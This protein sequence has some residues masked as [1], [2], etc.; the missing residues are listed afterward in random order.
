MPRVHKQKR[1]GTRLVIYLALHTVAC[2]R[3]GYELQSGAN[4]VDASLYDAGDEEVS[5]ANDAA[6]PPDVSPKDG[7][8]IEDADAGTSGVGGAD[9]DLAPLLEQGW[10]VVFSSDFSSHSSDFPSTKVTECGAFG[11]VLGGVDVLGLKDKINLL[12]SLPT[13]SEVQ[14]IADFVTIDSWDNERA[15]LDIENQRMVEISCGGASSASCNRTA[16]QCGNVIGAIGLDGQVR[17]Q[18]TLPHS[19]YKVQIVIGAVLDQP[20]LDESWGVNNLA[21]LVR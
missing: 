12:L 13:H 2:G 3:F 14:V 5:S 17:M 21:V 9:L 8:M 11:S 18:A 20:R 1:T 19:A 16:D 4:A 6:N 10:K 15:Y 7:A